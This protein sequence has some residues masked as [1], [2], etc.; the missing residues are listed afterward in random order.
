[1]PDTDVL[2]RL[3]KKAAVEAVNEGQP[4]SVLFGTVKS[5]SPLVISIDG[6]GK[7]DLPEEFF[8]LTRNVKDHKIDL[9]V[10]HETEAKGG[11]SGEAA[12]SSHTHSYKGRKTFLVHNNLKAGER[13]LLL[14]MQGGNKFIVLDRMEDD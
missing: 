10:D 2:V 11:G 1:M 8:Y 13:V 9:T 7:R 14:M 6:D 4:C 5:A 12:F 3:V